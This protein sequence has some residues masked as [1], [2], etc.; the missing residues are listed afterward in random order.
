MTR[1]DRS[2]PH[3]IRTV[4]DTAHWVA[5]YRAMESE[6]DDALFHDPW[7]RRLAGPAGE[8]AVRT[9]P[10]GR[11]TAWA[12]VVRT[13][14]MDEMIL[15]LVHE[16]EVDVVVN[17]AAGLDTRAYRLPLPDS[18]RWVEID[19]P[20]I[21]EE[22]R[23]VMAGEAPCCALRSIAADLADAAARATAL[24]DALA[25]ARRALVVTEGLLVY[26]GEE[27]VGALARD[28]YAH[29][30]CEWWLTDLASPQLLRIMGRSYSRGLDEAVR[31]RFA[32][33]SGSAFFLPFGWREAEYR[34]ILLE[35]HR[36]HR[37]MR[38]A[39]LFRLLGRLSRKRAAAW[40]R[41]SGVL[42]LRREGAPAPASEASS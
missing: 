2:S 23:A 34:S 39:W 7:A 31:F 11:A 42:L 13:A 38:G 26:L 14:V 40:K 29:P 41:F 1:R 8:R 18:L 6:R 4:S 17:L 19:L 5:F 20:G 28:L 36:L 3:P 24:D 15:R 35:A 33:E 12:M 25:G 27:H 21:L 9:I 30:A 10:R 16:E 37:E 22:K 32:P